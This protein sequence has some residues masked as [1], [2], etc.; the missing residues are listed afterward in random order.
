[1]NFT[2]V[3][4]IV[5]VSLLWGC[6]NPLLNKSTQQS[7]KQSDSKKHSLLTELYNLFTNYQFIV[8]YIFNQFGSILYIY[9]LSQLSL[10]VAS[11][12]CNG[13]TFVT[14]AIMSY[15]IGE[16]I[17][18]TTNTVIG[19]ILVLIGFTLCVQQ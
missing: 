12:C 10:S 6:T 4:E 19:C 3:S 9:L 11:H 7:I 2:S 14:T 18:I 5:L 13:L 8:Y 15:I 17:T 16:N 1:M